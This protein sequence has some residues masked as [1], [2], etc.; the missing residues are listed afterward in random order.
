MPSTQTDTQKAKAQQTGLT[1][2][3]QQFA[4]G[5]MARHK[6]AETD[7]AVQAKTLAQ[8]GTGAPYSGKPPHGE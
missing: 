7:K 6:K 4:I 8:A 3:A 1:L 5:V 2:L